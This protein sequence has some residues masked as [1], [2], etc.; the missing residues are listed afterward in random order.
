M[1]DAGICKICKLEN[2]AANGDKPDEHLVELCRSFYDERTVGV[3]RAYAALGAKQRIDML[4]RVY[5]T[6]LPDNAEYCI[7]EDNRQY[8]IA[9]KQVH[10]DHIDLTLNRL[11]GLLDVDS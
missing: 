11:E 10:G 2:R 9:L 1:F 8:R 6:D 3:T 4:I 5:N 7:L